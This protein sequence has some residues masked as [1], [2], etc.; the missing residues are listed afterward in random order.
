[1]LGFHG[2][3][4]LSLS[5]NKEFSSR[6]RILKSGSRS[7]QCGGDAQAFKNA[8]AGIARTGANSEEVMKLFVFIGTLAHP[9]PPASMLA[10]ISTLARAPD[11]GEMS[12]IPSQ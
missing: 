8:R 2:I 12:S 7:R 10:L 3:S 5:S 1:M 11:S 9:R 6:A 4:F